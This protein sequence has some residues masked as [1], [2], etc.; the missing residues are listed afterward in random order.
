MNLFKKG[1]GAIAQEAI[2]GKKSLWK[3]KD[4]GKGA[5]DLGKVDEV[6]KKFDVGKML[7]IAAAIVAVGAA[8]LMIGEGINLASQGLAVLVASFK[9]LEN[10]GAA[11]GAVA[12]VMGGFVGMLAMMIPIIGVLGATA[13]AVWPGLLALGAVFVGMG[14]G[15]FLASYGISL[16][17]TSFSGLKNVGLLDIGL[18]IGA[19]TLSIIALGASMMSGIGAIGLGMLLLTLTSLS[20]VMSEL[21]PNMSLAGTGMTDFANGIERLNTAVKDLST[22][23]LKDLKAISENLSSGSSTGLLE[24]FANALTGG[25]GNAG[26]GKQEIVIAPFDINLKLNGKQIQLITIGHAKLA[27]G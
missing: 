11:L 25:G 8:L 27:S 15:I 18:G 19:I 14:A 9:G 12:I 26:G 10:A 17:V 5:K 1:G 4:F 7:S 13:I 21:G 23:K 20:L 2:P 16:M 6:A 24:K 3:G 22:E